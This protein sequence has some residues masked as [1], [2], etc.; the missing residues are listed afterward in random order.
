MSVLLFMIGL[1]IPLGLFLAVG[2]VIQAVR[3]VYFRI[4]GAT[5]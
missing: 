2:A 1:A 4:K 5:S 3:W